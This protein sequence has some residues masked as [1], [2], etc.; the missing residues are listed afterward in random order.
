MEKIEKNNHNWLLKG[1]YVA[2]PFEEFYLQMLRPDMN[3]FVM[4]M[5][6]LQFTDVYF[7]T[8]DDVYRIHQ[9]E[10]EY[11]G[12]PIWVLT[13]EKNINFVYNLKY[14]EMFFGK[15]KVGERFCFDTYYFTKKILCILYINKNIFKKE[16][17]Q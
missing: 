8:S 12:D 16:L 15:L 1:Y 5:G 6:D 17:M 7:E 2:Y 4:S 3:L 11:Q 9:I 13:C 14:E 10:G